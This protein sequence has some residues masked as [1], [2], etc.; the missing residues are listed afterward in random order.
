MGEAELLGTFVNR[1][2]GLLDRR[3]LVGSWFPTFFGGILLANI[4]IPAYGWGKVSKEWATLGAGPQIWAGLT[5]AA[6]LTTA[7]FVLHVA[8]TI[9]LFEGYGLPS[10]IASL[11]QRRQVARR[12]RLPESSS[13]RSYPRDSTLIRPT[14]LGNILTA[15][16]EYSYLRYRIDAVVWWPRLAAVLPTSFR[17]QLDETLLPLIAL[18]NVSLVLIIDAVASGIA[19]IADMHWTIA[20]PAFALLAMISFLTYCAALPAATSYAECI[21]TAFDLY[22]NDVLSAMHLSLPKDLVAERSLWEVLTQWVHRG[23]PPQHAPLLS[24]AKVLGIDDFRYVY[25]QKEEN[26]PD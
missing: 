13:L 10:R 18:T 16:E 6:T 9:R 25:P 22:R 23:E 7:A 4:L 19:L 8:A 26:C 17:D 11:G 15:A 3:F 1:I 24:E 14:R 21:R 5:A 20:V 2:T 12:S